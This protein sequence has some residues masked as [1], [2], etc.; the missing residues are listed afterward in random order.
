MKRSNGLKYGMKVALFCGC[1]EGVML[2]G[3]KG[4]PY[5]CMSAL[6]VCHYRDIT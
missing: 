6:P 4:K 3:G 2:V 5:A 1:V